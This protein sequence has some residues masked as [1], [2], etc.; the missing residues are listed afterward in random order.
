VRSENEG[1]D[2]GALVHGTGWKRD[3]LKIYEGLRGERG[4][5]SV[6]FIVNL[7]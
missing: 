7:E 1:G 3:A 5:V 6:V 4:Q 2:E